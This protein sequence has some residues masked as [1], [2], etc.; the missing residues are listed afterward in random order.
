[1]AA[2]LV[3]VVSAAPP[4]RAP[5]RVMEKEQRGIRGR[6]MERTMRSAARSES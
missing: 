4:G 3:A 1:M 2:V 6:R 5:K